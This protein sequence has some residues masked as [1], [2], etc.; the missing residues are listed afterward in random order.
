MEKEFVEFSRVKITIFGIAQN[1]SFS[2][3]LYFFQYLCS[4]LKKGLLFRRPSDCQCSFLLF[5]IVFYTSKNNEFYFIQIQYHFNCN[6]Y[7]F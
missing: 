2:M 4:L 3:V 1:L 7:E 5:I 6:L